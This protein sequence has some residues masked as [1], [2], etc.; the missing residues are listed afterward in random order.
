[1]SMWLRGAQLR[2]LERAFRKPV[3][4]PVPTQVVSSG[5][6]LPPA[7]TRRQAR[8]EWLLQRDADL[9]AGRQGIARSRYLRSQ[10]GMAAAFLAMN[11]VYGE[12]YDVAPVEAADRDAAEER[13]DAT[14]GQFIFDVHTHHVHDDYRW[15]GQ[16][17]L[18]AAARGDLFGSEPWNPDLVGQELDLKYYKFDYY[19]K[20]MFF[21][22][23]TTLAL[24]STS[25]SVDPHK[26]LLS[27][28]Q[29]VATR[30]LVNRLAGT[31]RM[32]A[33]GVIWPSVPQY[34]PA[35]D[36]AATELKVDAWKGYT[37][38]D[39]LGVTPTF[40]HPW[41]MDDEDLTY[42][43]YEKAQH[44]GVRNICVHKGVLPAD[45]ERIPTWRYATVEDVGKAAL[46]WPGL[47]FHIYHA[48]LRMWRDLPPVVAEFEDTGRL[49]WIDEVAAIPA[50]YGVSNVYADVGLSFGA[51]AVS[52]PRLAA[53]LLGKLIQGLGTDHV[54]W[55]TDSI[56]FGSPQWQIE[57]L[58]R[59]EIP[60]DLQD[61][62]GFEPLGAAD[63]PVK[64]AIFGATPPASTASSWTRRTP[65]HRL[66][67]GRP[68]PPQG[69]VP[70]GR[71]PARQPV[72]GLDS[73]ARRCMTTATTRSKLTLAASY[74][75]MLTY[76]SRLFDQD[77]RIDRRV[78]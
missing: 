21:D 53:A 62:H 33:H 43:S 11:Q 16:L 52:E 55:G 46:D 75:I 9:H 28:D 1:M 32:F 60:P 40:E 44:H 4:C 68:V 56:W 70:G 6:C 37:M 58:R 59:I 31:R 5:E 73:H 25:P 71:P 36:R 72:L 78:A 74:V 17:W 18:R 48:G 63:G 24:L 65:G 8:V 10:S 22:S 27:D 34:L 64:S 45:Y 69:G 41:R 61:R 29:M 12:V 23:D 38:G 3:E 2:G 30:N 19:L 13:R 15:E 77:R 35:M 57:A 49:P 54:L 76:G 50:R 39:V 14:R 42:P 47:N 20:D 7:Q 51:L 67:R 66:C 26:M